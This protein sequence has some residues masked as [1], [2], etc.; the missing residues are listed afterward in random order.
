[1]SRTKTLVIAPAYCLLTACLQLTPR[2]FAL[3]RGAQQMQGD[4][5]QS[6]ITRRIGAIKAIDNNVITLAPDSGAEITV[7]V[8][9]TARILRVAPGEKNL[10]NATPA[11]WQDLQVGDRILVGGEASDDAKSIAASS[12]VV[13]KQ[14]D[15]EARQEQ[16]LKDWQR[17]AGGLVTAVDP[18]SRTVTVSVTGFG[19]TKS[20]AIRA[21]KDTVIRRYAPGSMK[22]E[23]AKASTLEAIHP[24]DQLRARGSRGLDGAELA[25]EEIVT[26]SFRNVAGTIKSV[27]AAA[28]TIMVDD[29]L[30]KKS[31]QVRIAPESQLRKLPPELAQRLAVRLKGGA[32][33]APA[34]AGANQQANSPVATTGNV[35]GARPGSIAEMGPASGG[36]G[37]GGRSG[38]APDFQQMLNRMPAVTLSDLHRGDAVMVVTTQGT[39][40]NGGTPNEGAS[41]GGA[42][43]EGTAITLL[44]GVEAILQ[45][46]P[47]GSQAMMLTPWSLGGPSGDAQNQ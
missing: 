22:F 24:G 5:G 16:T 1:M 2:C 35:Q 14:S 28:G 18:V 44:S 36:M 4:A 38:A 47:S 32:V 26:G 9:A 42:F 10:K 45:A 40:S 41:N 19:G 46:T 25:A 7:T 3:P 43:H 6:A 11:Q 13:M 34:A 27:D 20:V 39:S 33:G 15:V 12:I 30:S 29:V 17:G 21:S 23:D 8:K 37:G 31:V